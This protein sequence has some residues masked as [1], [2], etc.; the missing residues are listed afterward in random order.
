[1]GCLASGNMALGGVSSY[2]G[3]LQY[4]LLG[5]SSS[6][7][8]GPALLMAVSKPASHAVQ[9]QIDVNSLGIPCQMLL[10]CLPACRWEAASEQKCKPV[11]SRAS[12]I[13][14]WLQAQIW[15]TC[16]PTCA[17]GSF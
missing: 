6:L 16:R 2:S 3:P 8:I 12:S 4:C 5:S 17:A 13:T 14:G 9:L 7:W 11:H 1:M 10:F 15:A